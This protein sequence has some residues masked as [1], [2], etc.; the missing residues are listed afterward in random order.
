MEHA[1][2]V[3]QL[4][5]SMTAEHEQP[6]R[7][8]LRQAQQGDGAAVDEVLQRHRQSLKR[9][10]ASRLDR[11]L[12]ARVDASDI[13]Q[14]VLWEA[15]RRY[16]EFLADDGLPFHLWLRRLA[17]DRI[18]DMHRRHRL[19]AKRSID[20]ER[21]LDA[22]YKGHSS[23]QLADQ[24]RDAELTPAAAAIRKELQSRFLEAIDQLGEADR[25]VL[26]MR[27]CEQMTNQEVAQ[28]LECSHATAGMRYLRALRKLRKVLQIHDESLDQSRG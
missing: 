4:A 19:A 9:M 1:T 3:S 8:L 13:V 25:E 27:H 2:I 16:P 12:A 15:S 14:D 24:L 6:T 28:A 7:Q 23:Y 20:R 5:L 22:A 18:I 26:L 21:R 11:A 17:R 10:I